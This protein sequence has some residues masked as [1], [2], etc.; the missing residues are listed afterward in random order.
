M[1]GAK[2]TFKASTA[3]GVR[4]TIA[5]TQG[6]DSFYYFEVERNPSGFSLA[7]GVSGTAPE[8]PPNDVDHPPFGATKDSVMASSDYGRA[9]TVGWNGG[10]HYGAD[11]AVGTDATLGFA[12]DYRGKYPVVYII[13]SSDV[14][15]TVCTTVG[16]PEPCVFNRVQLAGVGPANSLYIYAYGKG[17][18]T[19]GPSVVLNTG[20]D[21]VGRP[22]IHSQDGVRK[23]LRARWYQGDRGFTAQWPTSN[24]VASAP[25]LTRNGN[26]RIV[27]RD[28]DTATAKAHVCPT[29]LA[30]EVHWTDENG[31]VHGDGGSLLLT[32]AVTGAIGAGD[33][34]LLAH[35]TDPATGRYAELRYRLTIAGSM[36]DLDHD[37][38]GLKYS[39]EMAAHTNPANPDSDGDG[40]SDGVEAALGFDPAR[41]DTDRNGVRDGRQLAGAN[42]PEFGALAMESGV[43]GTSTGVVLSEDSLAAAF[44]LDVNQDC[45]Q[46]HPP[47]AAYP[48]DTSYEFC[49][50]RAVRANVG[51]GPGEFRYFETQRLGAPANAGQGVIERVARI[52]PYCCFEN[53]VFPTPPFADTPPSLSYNSLGSMY[54]R[55]VNVPSSVIPYEFNPNATEYYGFAVDYTDGMTPVVYVVGTTSAG[56]MNVSGAYSLDGFDGAEVVPMVYG[57]PVSSTEATAR[58]NL[59]LEKFHYSTA[60]VRAALAARGNLNVAVFTP[61]VGVHRRP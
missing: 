14:A 8:T 3:T 61:G 48:F 29:S 37:G 27:V 13:G 18:G 45:V 17:N 43:N 24:G 55:L 53:G 56:E 41:A 54:V 32:P 22:F 10:T 19:D 16:P 30:S 26:G 12:V 42:L 21:L 57:H 33:H 44:T 23:A 35:V 31:V 60:D 59:G 50:K 25:T 40:L 58:I 49:I 47:F 9:F 51:V 20:A 11:N 5:L 36:T 38:D 15:G 7:V 4:S 34:T 28:G 6:P 2:A 46:L 52:D 1:D 39:E